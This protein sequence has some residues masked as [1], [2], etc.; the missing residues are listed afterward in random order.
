MTGLGKKKMEAIKEHAAL[1][2]A[3]SVQLQ[4]NGILGYGKTMEY[5]AKEI[6]RILEDK[7]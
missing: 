7:V 4:D 3:F 1:L 2:A 6:L 5:H